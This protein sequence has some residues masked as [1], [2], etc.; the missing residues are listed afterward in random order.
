V[1]LYPFQRALKQLVHPFQVAVIPAEALFAEIVGGTP[2]PENGQT[3][4]GGFAPAGG[5][6][7]ADAETIPL[8][9]TP[10]QLAPM[11]VCLQDLN[12]LGVERCPIRL[13]AA[14]EAE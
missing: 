5:F 14:G 6:R 8:G 12:P 11:P 3:L 7:D 2:L 13:F 1:G 4:F 10:P 9:G